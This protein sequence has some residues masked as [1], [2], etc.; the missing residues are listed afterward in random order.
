MQVSEGSISLLVEAYDDSEMARI[1]TL[2]TEVAKEP[3]YLPNL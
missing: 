2:M 1:N 3:P